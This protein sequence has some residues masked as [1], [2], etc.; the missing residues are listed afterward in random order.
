[1]A[2][3]RAIYRLMPKTTSPTSGI[4]LLSMSTMLKANSYNNIA[5]LSSLVK[6][7]YSTVNA[8]ALH[9][10]FG[11]NRQPAARHSTS[12][13]GYQT[14]VSKI[15]YLVFIYT[16]IHIQMLEVLIILIISLKHFFYKMQQVHISYVCMLLMHRA[17]NE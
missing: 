11:S 1:M 15:E 12:S 6:R 5:A 8:C 16:Y 2:S 3:T 10:V 13:F 9:S 4:E 7:Q 17:S 14:I